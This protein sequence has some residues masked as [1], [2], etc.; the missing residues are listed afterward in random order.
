S[1]VRKIKEGRLKPALPANA[2]IPLMQGH[3][4]LSQLILP[5]ATWA[6]RIRV[7][8]TLPQDEANLVG[9]P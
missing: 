4:T 5:L 2:D 7:M 3:E 8:P 6:R 1:S 9:V